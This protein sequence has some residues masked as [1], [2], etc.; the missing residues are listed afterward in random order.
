MNPIGRVVGLPADLVAGLRVLP[1][2]A[3]DMEAVREA[4]NAMPDVRQATTDMERHTRALPEVLESLNVV[5]EGA[6]V[7]KPMDERMQTIE[8]AMPVLVEVQQHLAQLPETMTDLTDVLGKLLESMIRLDKN[9]SALHETL[10]P[11]APAM[12]RLDQDVNSLHDVVEP[13][14]RIADRVPLRNRKSS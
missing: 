14:G 1:K 3:R 2:L 6:V 8:G 4:T 10:E 7:L 11:L 12:A 9:V 13:L 5:A